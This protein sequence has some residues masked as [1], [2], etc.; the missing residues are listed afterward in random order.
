MLVGAAARQTKPTTGGGLYFGM[1]AAKLA[2]DCAAQAI[3]EHDA[4]EKETIDALQ[5]GLPEAASSINPVDVLGDALADRYEL[6]LETVLKDSGSGM[7]RL[8]RVNVYGLST[9]IVA[10]FHQQLSGRVFRSRQ[11]SRTGSQKRH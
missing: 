1:R 10:D 6:A 4:L 7:D 8:I 2:A 11:R 9:S 5:A 3:E